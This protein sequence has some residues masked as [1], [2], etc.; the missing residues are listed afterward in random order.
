MNFLRYKSEHLADH[1]RGA[2]VQGRLVEPLPT[3][4]D[5]SSQLGV[6][7]DT[8]QAALRILKREGWVGSRPRQGFYLARKPFRRV[9]LQRPPVVRW[10][11]YGRHHTYNPVTTETVSI[12]SQRLAA[13]RIA[14]QVETCDDARL[15]AIHKEGPRPHELLGLPNYLPPKYLRCFAEWQNALL[16][17]EPL[18]GIRLP[19]IASD[20]FSAIRHATFVLC[21]RGFE[22]ISLVN[23]KGSRGVDEWREILQREFQR[24]CAIAPRPVQGEVIWLP[25]ETSEQYPAV[26]RLAKRIRSRHGFVTNAPVSPGL[27]MMA[28]MHR[29]LKIPAEVEVVAVN[30]TPQQ[31]L[32]FPRMTHYP[33]PFEPHSKAVCHAADHYFEQGALP[34]LHKVIPLTM[35]SRP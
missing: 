5:W 4:R 19:Y 7:P 31:T 13:H 33:Y 30:C 17:G 20:V 10:I 2:I 21:R 18:R 16:I 28:L 14:L 12:L 34:A 35:V 15:A 9:R 23:L 1:L 6:S 32:T 22:R 25:N 8:L 26:Q 29:G 24:I 27:L 11:L 3:L